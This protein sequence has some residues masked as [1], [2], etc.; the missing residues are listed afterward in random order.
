MVDDDGG[1]GNSNGVAGTNGGAIFALMMS[2]SIDVHCRETVCCISCAIDVKAYG[3]GYFVT[4]ATDATNTNNSAVADND[5]DVAA[6]ENNVDFVV[7]MEDMFKRI[8]SLKCC[9]DKMEM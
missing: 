5:A 2:R 7:D 6:V 3:V 4:G 8:P 9:E 1:G